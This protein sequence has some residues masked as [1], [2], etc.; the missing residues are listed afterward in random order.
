MKYD[1]IVVGARCAGSSL[2]MLLARGGARVLLVDRANFPSDTLNGHYIHP[3]GVRSLERWGLLDRVLSPGSARPVRDVHMDFGSIAFTGHLGWPDGEDAFS[4]APR[5]HRL[6]ALLVDAA[7]EAGAEV[8]QAFYVADLLRDG[9]RVVGIIGH[10]VDGQ[11]VEE[12]A[13]LVV[14]ADGLRSMVAIRVGARAYETIPAQTCIYY[15][16]WA[17]LA[18]TGLEIYL[19]PGRY[20]LTF[21]TD[22][23]LTCVAVGWRHSEFGRV[24][25]DVE[26]E[27]LSALEAAP[28]LAARVRAAR[29]VEPFRG[30]AD[31][32]MYLREPSGPGWALVG[33]AGCRVDPITGEGITDAFRDA[34]L[35]ADA[36]RGGLGGTRPLD[37]AL[38]LY[39]RRRDAAVTP[40]YHYTAQRARLEPLT[41]EQTH[42]MSAV[43]DNHAAADRFVGLTAGTTAFDD[44]FSPAH[45]RGL[46]GQAAD[47]AA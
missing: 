45:I 30:T 32:P 33:D 5:R 28:D 47:R 31:V 16:H 6:D 20:A 23:G 40:V 18:T 29:R 2:A 21:P 3:A 11:A 44:F 37:E 22:A 42:L 14:G 10:G 43:A 36:I 38:N 9:E 39:W 12:H 1:V 27:F 15:S 35:L 17:D 24:R 19:R 7:A 25:T 8:R 26:G 41:M 4:V 46:V 34:G 13:E